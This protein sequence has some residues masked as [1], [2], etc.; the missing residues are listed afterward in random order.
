MVSVPA[1]DMFASGSAFAKWDLGHGQRHRAAGAVFRVF[2]LGHAEPLRSRGE[3]GRGLADS[4][5]ADESLHPQGGILYAVAF[6]ERIESFGGERF[7]GPVA[8]RGQ[9]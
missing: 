1:S 5:R 2:L 6:A 8:L 3:Q 7:D 4:A 9:I